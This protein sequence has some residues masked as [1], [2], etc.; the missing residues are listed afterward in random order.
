M[1]KKASK[2]VLVRDW[3]KKAE[4]DFGMARLA[5]EHEPEY[6]DQICFHCQ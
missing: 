5:L 1:G 3:V 4:H 6:T 2:V